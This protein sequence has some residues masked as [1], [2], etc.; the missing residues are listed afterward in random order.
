MKFHRQL[1]SLDLL[2]KEV[3]AQL[4]A[5]I[6]AGRKSVTELTDVARASGMAISRSAVFRYIKREHRRRPKNAGSVPEAVRLYLSLLPAD[7]WNFRY[8]LSTLEPGGDWPRRPVK[9]VNDPSKGV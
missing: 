7:R 9:M 3:K 8:I 4:D 1:S 5:E 2:P 6:A